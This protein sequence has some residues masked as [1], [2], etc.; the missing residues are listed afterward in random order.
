MQA[1][2]EAPEHGERPADDAVPGRIL[3]DEGGG[4]CL[5]Q[6]R[7]VG[8]DALRVGD[9]LVPGE[10]EN[11]VAGLRRLQQ[12]AGDLQRVES[13]HAIHVGHAEHHRIT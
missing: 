13:D 8:N 12:R 5:A 7:G 4:C 10:Q 6:Q 2:V 9:D 1:L 3:P 11:L